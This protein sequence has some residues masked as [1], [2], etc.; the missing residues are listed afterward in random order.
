MT[1]IIN[2]EGIYRYRYIDR[3][4]LTKVDTVTNKHLKP[5]ALIKNKTRVPSH[6]L[7]KVKIGTAILNNNLVILVNLN[8]CQWCDLSILM[9]H[10]DPLK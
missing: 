3:I 9:W 5:R 7:V 4:K 10:T 8:Q 6:L 1:N 2:Q